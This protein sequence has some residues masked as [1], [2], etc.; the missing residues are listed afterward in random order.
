MKS[1]FDTIWGFNKKRQDEEHFRESDVKGLQRD[2]NHKWQKKSGLC[3]VRVRMQ[4]VFLYNV[5]LNLNGSYFLC[6]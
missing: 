6:R 2:I 4:D 5:Y 3:S 1:F